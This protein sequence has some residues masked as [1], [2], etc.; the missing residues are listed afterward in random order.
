MRRFIAICSIR[1]TFI[2]CLVCSTQALS[3]TEYPKGVYLTGEQLRSKTPEK[4]LEVIVEERS[5]GDKVMMG[6]NDFKIVQTDGAKTH[7]REIKRDWVA[8]SDGNHLYIN[9]FGLGIQIWYCKVISE[10]S[11]LLFYGAM[12]ANEAAGVAVATGALGSAAAANTKRLYLYDLA[13]LEMHRVNRDLTEAYLEKY[14]DLSEKFENEDNPKKAETQLLYLKAVNM[15]KANGNENSIARDIK[16]EPVYL[17][18]YRR[19]RKEYPEPISIHVQ[20]SI[21]YD[22]VPDFYAW[23]EFTTTDSTISI[24]WNDGQMNSNLDINISL[25]G[26]YYIAISQPISKEVATVELVDDGEGEW[27]SELARKAHKK[28]LARE[29]D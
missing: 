5:A 16:G 22:V 13:S 6:G 26:T 20:D 3:Q 10:G 12:S 9:G 27:D 19:S 2:L 17:V 4:Q 14:T 7:Q 29:G 11:F 1:L 21:S 28:R 23:D 18:F 24:T 15:D 8:Y 25:Q